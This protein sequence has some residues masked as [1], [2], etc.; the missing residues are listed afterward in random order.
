MEG[1]LPNSSQSQHK[2]ILLQCEIIWAK[3]DTDEFHVNLS[4][5][6]LF[7]PGTSVASFMLKE[8][9]CAGS[10]IMN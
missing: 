5:L 10:L 3:G 4:S 2:V 1:L 8:D 7:T 9:E 6:L